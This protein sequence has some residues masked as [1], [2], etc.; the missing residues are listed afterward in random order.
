MAT[1]NLG[2]IKPVFRGAWT[3]GAYVIDDIVTHGDESF[4]CIQAGTNIATSN[5]SYWTK[6]AAKG[7]NGTNGTDLGTVITTQGDIA[8]RDGSGL[9]RL[10]KPASDKIL[11]NTSGGVLSWIEAPSGKVLQ[12]K[13]ATTTSVIT[14]SG[15]T[16]KSFNNSNSVSNGTQIVS[17][18]ITP[19]STTSH[20]YC[21]Y[22]S[23]NGCNGNDNGVTAM[24][25][26]SNKLN[27][28]I[29]NGN[30]ADVGT[31]SLHGQVDTTSLSG[32]QTIQVRNMG[33]TNSSS[34]THYINADHGGSHTGTPAVLTVME[35]ED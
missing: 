25:H 4:I 31:A 34:N 3:S 2:R 20:F 15:D 27:V 29:F 22:T 19:L 30:S 5:A 33:S 6:M 8:Y 24:Y 21:W 14:H 35:I 17:V 18:S 13:R 1:L 23:Q 26:G 12:T 9:Q 32:A 11:Q 10:A 16:G 28:S 7:T